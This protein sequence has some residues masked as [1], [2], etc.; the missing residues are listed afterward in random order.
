[1]LFSA[2]AIL[3]AWRVLHG[4]YPGSRNPVAAEAA[5]AFFSPRDR[6]IWK[7][8]LATQEVKP[9]QKSADRLEASVDESGGEKTE[10]WHRCLRSDS[11]SI[12]KIRSK[13]RYFGAM[14]KFIG[15]PTRPRRMTSAAALKP[16]NA[17][18]ICFRPSGGSSSIFEKPSIGRAQDLK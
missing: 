10:S 5:E 9:G 8:G 17:S 14:T 7:G 11:R 4:A 1:M 15:W 12:S 16:F 18:T 6:F 13:G 3:L 2:G